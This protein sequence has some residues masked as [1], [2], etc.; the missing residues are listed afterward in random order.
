[1][2]LILRLVRWVHT[3]RTELLLAIAVATAR[4]VIQRHSGRPAGDIFFIAVGQC[5]LCL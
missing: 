5:F 1:M 4:D 3:W 2:E